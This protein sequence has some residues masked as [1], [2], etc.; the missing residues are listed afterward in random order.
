MKIKITEKKI[1][2]TACTILGLLFYLRCINEVFIYPA[3]IV[4]LLLI[5]LCKYKYCL[6]SLMFIIPFSSIYKFTP[7]QITFFTILFLIY[8]A[9]ILFTRRL[10][11]RMVVLVIIFFLY[12]VLFSGLSEIV[13]ILTMIFGFLMINEVCKSKNIDFYTSIYS[14]SFGLIGASLLALMVDYLPI[15]GAFVEKGTLW[16]AELGAVGN[17]FKGLTSNSNYYAF[18]L[19]VALSCLAIMILKEKRG[20]LPIILFIVLSWFGFMTVSKTFLLIWGLLLVMILYDMLKYTRRKF[21]TVAVLLILGGAIIIAGAHDIIM[22]YMIR[23]AGAKDQSLAQFTTHRSDLWLMYFKAFCDNIKIFLVGDG[24]RFN[25][26]GRW[27]THNTYIQ[28]LYSLGI[29]GTILYGTILRTAIRLPKFRG[30]DRMLLIPLIVL[31]INLF[32]IDALTNDTLPFLI[33]LI[34]QTILYYQC[35]VSA[36]PDNI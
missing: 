17:R 34:M 18:Y 26:L 21:F 20:N 14:F 31:L 16:S 24:L 2:T 23:F 9:R 28:I 32:A 5:S 30:K 11:G 27:A 8:I 1:W 6:P 15:L 29:V 12:C 7:D 4:G 35:N 19:I 3:I 22:M 33:V 10:S 36:K 25:L 13:T